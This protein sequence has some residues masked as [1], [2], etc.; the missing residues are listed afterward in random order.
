M[1]RKT[2]FNDDEA[3]QWKYV[4]EKSAFDLDFWSRAER[5][6]YNNLHASA[7][8]WCETE[9]VHSNGSLIPASF[10]TFQQSVGAP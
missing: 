7:G 4:K 8:L 3:L 5:L 6:H 1:R 10:R 2:A 9:E